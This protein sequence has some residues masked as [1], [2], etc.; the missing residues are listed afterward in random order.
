MKKTDLLFEISFI[1][2]N[3]LIHGLIIFVIQNAVF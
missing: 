1:R 3:I 2:S